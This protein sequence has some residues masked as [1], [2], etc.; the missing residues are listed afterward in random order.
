M[1]PRRRVCLN[2]AMT[3]DKASGKTPWIK[4]IHEDSSELP[5]ELQTM[6]EAMRDPDGHVDNIL[7]IHSLHPKS[8]QVHYDFYKMVMYG[9]SKLSRVRREMLAVAISAANECHY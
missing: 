9:P 1:I 8:L 5:P 6:Y 4:V 7:K 3:N 2:T